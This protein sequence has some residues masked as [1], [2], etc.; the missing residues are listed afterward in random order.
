M[1]KKRVI[2]NFSSCLKHAYKLAK[3]HEADYL[4]G[5]C[6]PAKDD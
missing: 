2:G 5:W 3:S 6:G 1:K 4:P